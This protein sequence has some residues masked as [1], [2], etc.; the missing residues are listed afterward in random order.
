MCLS[1]TTASFRRS[2][3]H[4]L[5]GFTLQVN[6]RERVVVGCVDRLRKDGGKHEVRE[7]RDVWW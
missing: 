4:T 3:I 6:P 2:I 5:P 1:T 7:P